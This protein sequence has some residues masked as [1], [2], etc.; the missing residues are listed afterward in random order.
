MKNGKLQI[1]IIG[2]GGISNQ[3]HMPNLHKLGNLC[4]LVAFCDL[5]EERAVKA[6][7]DFGT[8]DAKVYTDYQALLKDP[9]IDLVHVL[10]PNVSHCPITVAAFEAGKHIM[11]EKPIPIRY[12]RPPP[13][14][15]RNG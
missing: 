13:P 5:I 6:K 11:C 4:E 7:Q 12:T 14:C 2:C 1:G 9:E 15:I 8:P 3:K 10:T